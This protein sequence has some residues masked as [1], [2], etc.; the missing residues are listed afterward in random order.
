VEVDKYWMTGGLLGALVYI[1]EKVFP[2]RR[3]I[4]IHWLRVAPLP[5][6]FA[7]TLLSIG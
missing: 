5:N 7:R 4:K 6:G 1:F 2:S 3:I